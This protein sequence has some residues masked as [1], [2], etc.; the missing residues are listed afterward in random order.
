MQTKWKL[1]FTLLTVAAVSRSVEAANSYVQTNLVSDLPGIAAQ[2][3]P[4]LVNP[5]GLAS[6]ASSPFWISDNHAGTE[7]LY[8]GSGQPFP[9]AS[10]LVVQIPAPQGA[11]PPAAP[12]GVVYNDTGGFLLG[13]TAASFIF[14]SEDGTIT[15]WDGAS[16]GSAQLMADNSGA[17][18]VYKGLAIAVS[19]AGP[20]LYATNFAAGTIDTFD[21]GFA[22]VVTP[23]GFID[24]AVPS[25]FAPFGI[26]RIGRKLYVSY[27]MQDSARHDDVAGPG[28]GFIDVFDFDGNL[29]TR[30]VSNGVLNSPW[31]MTL[32][33]A[34][35]GDFGDLLLVGNFGD[36]TINAFDPVTGNYA[37][38]LE[39]PNGNPLVV[40]GLWALAFGNKK[41]GGDAT[42]LY[43][44]AGIPGAGSLED[45]G[46]FGSIAPQ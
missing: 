37:G 8:N 43:F 45:H 36:G 7:T 34:Y 26:Q 1:C 40:Q 31:G 41:N 44:T 25:G 32:A 17:G 35:F 18:A 38:T 20:R 14:S 28:N 13:G 39:D 19:T 46:L 10:P 5:W 30:L 11:Q 9:A 22:P 24:P 23:G 6:S 4:N 21:T 2:I 16:G 15:A 3:D 12:S 27:A 33:P 42:T 29:V